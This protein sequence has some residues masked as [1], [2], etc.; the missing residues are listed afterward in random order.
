MQLAH[1]CDDDLTG[2]LVGVGAEGRVLFGQ[3]HQGVH[4]LLL[5]RAGLGLD[6][7]SDNRLRELHRLKNYGILFVGEGVTGCGVL[8]RN[9]SC[10]ITRA[11]LI[12][13]LTVVCVHLDDTSESLA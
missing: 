9:N 2:L 12:D 11:D 13:I 5:T 10:D 8:Y 1:T 4:H 7:N 3:L 6:G